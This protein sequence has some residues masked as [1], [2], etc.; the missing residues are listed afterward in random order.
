MGFMHMVMKNQQ[1]VFLFN[2]NYTLSKQMNDTDGPFS[3][4][5]DSQHPA[6]EWGPA[7]SDIRHRLDSMLSVSLPKGVRLLAIAAAR[8]AMPYTVTTGF[9]DNG[10]TVSNDRPAGVGRNRA[11]AAGEFEVTARLGWAIGF[12][13]P[14]GPA[15]PGQGL[16]DARSGGDP[17]GALSRSDAQGR[18][19]R[20]EL[21]LQAYNLLNR[22]NPIG[23]RGVQ[24]SPFFGQA[25]ASLPPRRLEVGTR[26][27]F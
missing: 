26:F 27:D 23:Y 4:P 9:D 6:A 20:L 19:C 5:V 12:G 17:L 1:L 16:S 14:R 21:Y 11:R 7:A 13:K 18:R 25:T 24:T 2:V 15:R 8:S 22:V 3:L 10:D